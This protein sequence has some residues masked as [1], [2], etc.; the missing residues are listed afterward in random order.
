MTELPLASLPHKSPRPAS[1]LRSLALKFYRMTVLV[2]IVCLIKD[3]YVRVRVQGE[4]PIELHEVKSILP[5]AEALRVDHSERM[6]L[7]I[8]DQ[9]QQTIGYAVRTSP[10]SDEIIG[11]C[12]PTDTL[13][14]FEQA[15]GKIAGLSIRRSGDTTSH[16]KDVRKNQYYMNRWK[17]YSWDDL[18]ILDLTQGD[19]EGVSGATMTSM[20]IAH[21]IAF[22][23]QH[24]HKK[25]TDMQPFNLQPADGLLIFFCFAACLITFT[26]LKQYHWLRNLFK[27]SALIYLGFLSG[28]LLAESLFA[29][30]ARYTIPWRQFFG[31]VVLAACAFLIPWTTRRNIYCQSL[32]PHG[33]AQ[34]LLGKF[35]PAK[36]KWKIRADVKRA[37]RWIPGFL[38]CLIL[39]IIFLDLPIDLAELEAFDAYLLTSAGVLSICIAITG[40]MASLF[41]PQAYCHYGC[42][43]G[44]ILEFIRSHGRA[45]HFG[46]ADFVAALF[47]I[48]AILFNQYAEI[49]K[50]FIFQ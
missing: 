12:G 20:G 5:E 16:V 38:I 36:R 1:S 35:V 24:S 31:L 42:P 3:Y 4:F 48:M 49:L 22:R 28:D 41:V 7:F 34:E 6:G 14:V 2:L 39:I 23:I 13:L 45:D 33:T 43:T 44:A 17:Q 26:R 32:C 37:L 21:A 50:Q 25:I 29:G 9:N 27:L 10:I 18:V 11:Y 15:T 40:L 19:I 30:W 46:K 47:L 8:L